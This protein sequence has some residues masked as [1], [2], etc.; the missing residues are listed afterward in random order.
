MPLFRF[1]WKWP[2]AAPE[3]SAATAAAPEEPETL[4]RTC[5]RS[6]VLR[7]FEPGPDA[8]FCHLTASPWFVPFPVRECSE[9][10]PRR[11]PR[12]NAGFASG[13]GKEEP[14]DCLDCR[15]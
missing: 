6:H 1:D 11:A 10:T 8:V 14:S 5:T 12:A 15:P 7:G 9:F 3:P 13:A 2:V 4:C